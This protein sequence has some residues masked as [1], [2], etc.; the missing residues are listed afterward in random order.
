M[1]LEEYRKTIKDLSDDD[2]RSEAIITLSDEIEKDL[3]IVENY[4]SKLEEKEETINSLR[5]TNAK[6]ALRITNE[7][8]G[9]GE[10]EEEEIKSVDDLINMLKED[11]KE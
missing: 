5:E 3:A 10:K 4:N 7:Y 2:K 1:T 8:L 11:K 9:E 6:L